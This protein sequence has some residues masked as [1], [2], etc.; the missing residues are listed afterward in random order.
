MNPIA[1]HAGPDRRLELADQLQL[2]QR[3]RVAAGAAPDRADAEILGRA[4]IEVSHRMDAE[5]ERDM[6]EI[7]RGRA[8]H[9][10]GAAEAAYAV[11]HVVGGARV[12]QRAA[13][14]AARAPIFDDL[15]AWRDAELVVKPLRR[16]LSQRVL[17]EE[18]N[19]RP[20]V[21]VVEPV[22]IDAAQAVAKERRPARKLDGAPLALALNA[23]DL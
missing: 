13:G 20:H 8:D 7:V 22:D 5:R 1:R 15:G 11:L 6:D 18:R 23:L 4:R 19:L 21:G 16:N 9:D 17:G 3:G 12:E 2:I 10:K 14:H